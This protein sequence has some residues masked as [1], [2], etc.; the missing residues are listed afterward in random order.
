[1]EKAIVS[2]CAL[3][4]SPACRHFVV[5][6]GQANKHSQWSSK[7]NAYN[8]HNLFYGPR[9]CCVYS[10]HLHFA[11]HDGGVGTT[12]A[13]CLSSYRPP[14]IDAMGHLARTLNA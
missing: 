6:Q 14:V 10:T 5:S 8:A 11:V 7:Y 2:H 3:L 12:Q 1:M 13:H 4:K 9:C